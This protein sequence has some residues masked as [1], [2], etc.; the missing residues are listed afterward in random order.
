MKVFKTVIALL[1]FATSISAQFR[2]VGTGSWAPAGSGMWTATVGFSSDLTGNSYL[3]NQITTGFKLFTGTEQTYDISGVA[4]PT[5]SSA[6]LTITATGSTTNAP[7]GQVLVYDPDGRATIPQVPFASNG[8]TGQMQA[9][10]DTYNQRQAAGGNPSADNVNLNPNLDTDGDGNNETTAQAA[11]ISIKQELEPVQETFDDLSSGN[12]VA[13]SAPLPSNL[14]KVK[15]YRG[16]LL[17][18]RDIDYTISSQTVTFT[19]RAF[20]DGERVKVVFPK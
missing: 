3:P 4:N 18:E 15:V 9:A 17:Q 19:L 16:G 13:V 20:S 8:A 7:I 1:L 6:D 11:F 10:V 12:T 5:F 2:M 14:D